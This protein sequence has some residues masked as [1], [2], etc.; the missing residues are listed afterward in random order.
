MPLR[1][2]ARTRVQS[3]EV[4]PLHERSKIP[5]GPAEHAEHAERESRSLSFCVLPRL[6]RATPL[7]VMIDSKRLL[8]SMNRSARSRFAW[9]PGFSRLRVATPHRL[10]AGLRTPA[11]HGPNARFSP[12]VE[13]TH[14]PFRA[15]PLCMESRL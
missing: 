8:P 5:D 13:T 7:M 12:N 10:K 14:E 15:K 4:V 6:L 2:M 9:S 1:F 11:V 3:L